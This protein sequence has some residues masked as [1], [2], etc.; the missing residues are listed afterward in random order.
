MDGSGGA[1]DDPGAGGRVAGIWISRVGET[2]GDGVER[3]RRPCAEAANR[4]G[5]ATF[6]R[7][8]RT[9]VRG[10][11]V[12]EGAVAVLWVGAPPCPRG[13]DRF[14]YLLQA[15]TDLGLEPPFRSGRLWA[16]F[17]SPY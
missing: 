11:V 5:E 4:L 3:G 6:A 17:D 8:V 16:F 10:A 1:G 15:I 13:Y 2:A 9:A 12:R 7:G 14:P